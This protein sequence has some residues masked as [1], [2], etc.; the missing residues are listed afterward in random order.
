MISNILFPLTDGPTTHQEK[1]IGISAIGQLH[2]IIPFSCCSNVSFSDKLLA[3]DAEAS[4]ETKNNLYRLLRNL[5]NA[6]PNNNMAVMQKAAETFGRI[7]AVGGNLFAENLAEIE[8]QQAVD[9]LSAEQNEHARVAGSLIL[10]QLAMN[11]PSFYYAHTG[12]ILDRILVPLR[13]SRVRY[14]FVFYTITNISIGSCSA[15]CSSSALC[16]H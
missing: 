7:F 15:T 6:L 16:D 12:L 13:D 5:K 14:I 2:I 1:L 11:A 4:L 3:V 10:I 8:V 9:L